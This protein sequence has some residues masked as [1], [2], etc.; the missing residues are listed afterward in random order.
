[1]FIR[2]VGIDQWTGI[3]GGKSHDKFGEDEIFLYSW[4]LKIRDRILEG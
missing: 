2:E 1:M 4:V 3:V